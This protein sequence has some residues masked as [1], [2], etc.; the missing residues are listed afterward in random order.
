MKP[1]P[2]I[3]TTGRVI[4]IV[5]RPNVGKSA[6]FNRIV[7]R[8]LSIVHE[9]SGVTRDRV[10]A[11]A[12]AAG[13]RFDLYDTGGLGLMDGERTADQFDARI[14]EQAGVAIE[15]AAVL[16]LVVNGQD[17]L[18]PLD[19][20]VARQLHE[21]GRPVLLAVNKCDTEAADV[22]APEFEQ[23]GFPV[24][25]V[26][27]LHN[28][29]VHALMEEAVKHL[30]HVEEPSIAA[31]LRVAVVGKPNAGKSSFIN[32]LLRSDR[33]MVSEFAGTTR[34][35]VEIPFQVGEGEQARHYL[36]IDTAGMR[37]RR[38]IKEPVEAYSVMRAENS[39]QNADVVIHVIDA[40]EG[41]GSQD[42]KI[43]TMVQ[44]HEKGYLHL[45]N[46]WDLQEQTQRAYE[47]V[48][49][50]AFPFLSH[51]PKVYVSS[52]DGY[53]IRR[54]I[55]MVDYVAGQISQELTTGVLN[56][57][58]HDAVAATQPPSI[59]NKRGKFFYAAQ[60]GKRPIRI[61]LFVNDPKLFPDSYKQ[62]LIN[63]LR[64]AFGLEGAP[65]VLLLRARTRREKPGSPAP[66]GG[67]GKRRTA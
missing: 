25:P 52:K 1:E 5:G 43:S 28:R 49:E 48:L 20:A 53:N 67:R 2:Q 54:S 9:E 6:M 31:P 4:A 51:V 45:I 29:G 38:Q 34:D 44:K 33:V 42:K 30:P 17:G 65:I 60:A 3:Q 58:L 15:D 66:R 22:A 7:G 8:R 47:S 10:R 16:V 18:V 55:D 59:K 32:R 64:K 35:S 24:F 46:K 12:R 56:R 61:R 19:E 14:R 41:P 26:S 39:I 36:L 63:R 57:V 11:E 50:K 13:Q 23:L 37:R 27:A 21:S 62:Y 40:V